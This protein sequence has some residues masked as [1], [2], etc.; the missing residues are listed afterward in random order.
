M[1]N[2]IQAADATILNKALEIIARSQDVASVSCCY[3]Q[4]SDELMIRTERL[5][6]ISKLYPE[7]LFSS[8]TPLSSVQS[9]RVEN[10]TTF[11]TVGNPDESLVDHERV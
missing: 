2:K 7:M 11:R 5:S 10:Q 8:F 6:L 3:Y 4:E 1:A 9:K